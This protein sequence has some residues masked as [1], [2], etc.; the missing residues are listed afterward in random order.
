[1]K[2]LLFATGNKSKAK[3]F[4]KGLLEH[5]IKVLTLEDVPI[6]I[7]VEENGT[8][9][10]ENA[11]IKARAYAK[12]TNLPVFAMDD[13]LYLENV[14]EDKQPGMYVR[15]VNEKRLTDEEM[16]E[17]YSNLAK[18]YGTNGLITGRWIYGM[19]LISNGHE[20]T[21]TWS[22]ENFYI[23]SIPSKIINPG[24]PLNTISINI[25]LNKYFTDMTEEDKL[26]VQEDESHVVD[27][28][29]NSITDSKAKKK[30]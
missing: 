21:Y 11:L 30:K 13:T 15:R 14:P 1:M 18:E 28:L 3:R 20:Y 9:A 23:T 25:K 10:I 7:E 5:D 6:N 4:T 29:V 19:A 26:L 8:T 12:E 24:Y 17:Y 16:I 22:K 27:F 2:E